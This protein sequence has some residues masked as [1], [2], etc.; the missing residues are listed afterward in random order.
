MAGNAAQPEALYMIT[1]NFFWPNRGDTAARRDV[2][3]R[4][5]KGFEYRQSYVDAGKAQW[6]A[7]FG[8][9]QTGIII[10]R[11]SLEEFQEFLQ[12][13]PWSG[14]VKRNVKV[15]FDASGHAERYK[16][17]IANVDYDARVT[18]SP[19]ISGDLSI[20]SLAPDMKERLLD[21]TNNSY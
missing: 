20:V 17:A 13:D 6:F 4:I 9:V 11:T 12:R 8:D 2:D 10:L 21:T 1:E 5:I 7:H 14:I 3:A 18:D 19:L 15:V 16:A